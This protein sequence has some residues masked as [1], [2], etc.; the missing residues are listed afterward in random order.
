MSQKKRVLLILAVL[1]VV[2]TLGL[3]FSY[4]WFFPR[5]ELKEVGKFRIESPWTLNGKRSIVLCDIKGYQLTGKVGREATTIKDFDR[6]RHYLICYGCEVE[7]LRVRRY[8]CGSKISDDVMGYAAYSYDTIPL[9]D[10][11]MATV[12]DSDTYV[13]MYQ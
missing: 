12:Y 5:V 10:K 11:D 3:V 9:D 6:N 4:E 2:I 7:N 8:G 1:L 13:L